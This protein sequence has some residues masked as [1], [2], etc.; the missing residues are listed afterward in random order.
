MAA[1]KQPDKFLTLR[2]PADLHEQIAA[3]ATKN[4]RTI[5]GEVRLAIISHLERS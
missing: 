3:V 5:A 2:L 1:E 4:E